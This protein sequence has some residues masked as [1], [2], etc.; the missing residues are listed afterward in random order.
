MKIPLVMYHG[1]KIDI[2]CL[3]QLMQL[4]RTIGNPAEII[5]MIRGRIR[6]SGGLLDLNGTN[7]AEFKH[8]QKDPKLQSVR[9]KIFVRNPVSN[10]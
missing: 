6:N 1:R 9:I 8:A 4:F 5:V 3:P 7:F 2:Q 10:L